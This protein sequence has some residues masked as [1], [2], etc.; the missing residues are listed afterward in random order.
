MSLFSRDSEP[1]GVR[2]AFG[3][4]VNLDARETMWF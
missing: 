1:T 4:T 3:Y 2:V